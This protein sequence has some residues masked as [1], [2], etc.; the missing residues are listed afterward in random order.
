MSEI[1]KVSGYFRKNPKNL[2]IY[3]WLLFSVQ[4]NNN[5]AGTKHHL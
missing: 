2:N 4:E 3:P 1:R 5:F